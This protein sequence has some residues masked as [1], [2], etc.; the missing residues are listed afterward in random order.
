M[1]FFF[2]KHEGW[3]RTPLTNC[4]R[5][6]CNSNQLK[7]R[8]LSQ[9]QMARA[10]N[11]CSSLVAASATLRSIQSLLCGCKLSLNSML[12]L[13]HLTYKTKARFGAFM[14]LRDILVQECI[15][16]NTLFSSNDHLADTLQKKKKD[17]FHDHYISG[18]T[19]CNNIALS[20]RII[21]SLKKI[22]LCIILCDTRMKRPGE[23]SLIIYI[24]LY[25]KLRNKLHI[26]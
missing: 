1:C 17:S 8:N 7:F 26:S 19:R 12:Q 13:L 22:Q 10:I 20:L 3:F 18:T 24:E 23:N 2:T 16:L 9:Q 4:G 25:I 5:K 21:Q 6:Q 15:K 14:I 11:C